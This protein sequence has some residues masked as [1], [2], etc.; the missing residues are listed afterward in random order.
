MVLAEMEVVSCGHLVIINVKELVGIELNSESEEVHMHVFNPSMLRQMI[1]YLIS[2]DS[3]FR[4]INLSNC[5]LFAF[6][7]RRNWRFSSFNFSSSR[8][9]IVCSS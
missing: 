6:V 2:A 5:V 7:L 3:L 1:I 9:I 4:L 8:L